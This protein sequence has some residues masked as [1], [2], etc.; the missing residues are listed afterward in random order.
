MTALSIAAGFAVL[1]IILL[2][3]LGTIWV[4]NYQQFRTPMI[5]GLIVFAAVLLV[6]NGTA[7]YFFFSMDMLY[8]ADDDVHMA[9]AALRGMQCV[10]LAFLTWSTLQ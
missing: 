3:A 7:L 9:V 10:A 4:R 1:N 2:V 8:A 5:L 6:E